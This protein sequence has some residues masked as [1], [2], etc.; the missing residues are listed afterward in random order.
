MADRFLTRKEAEEALTIF[1]E[2]NLG[3]WMVSFG[4]KTPQEVLDQLVADTVNFGSATKIF[5]GRVALCFSARP[6]VGRRH[7]KLVDC[8][9]DG[10]NV[11][12]YLKVLPNTGA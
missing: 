7:Y 1:K 6:Y 4:G 5:L 10:G 8:A 11:V 2:Q 3:K 12:P 9:P